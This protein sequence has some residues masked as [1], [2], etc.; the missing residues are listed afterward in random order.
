MW[1][2]LIYLATQS[3]CQLLWRFKHYKAGSGSPLYLMMQKRYETEVTKLSQNNH[4]FLAV[5][6]VGLVLPL[7]YSAIIEKVVTI[8]YKRRWFL[9]RQFCKQHSS[10]IFRRNTCFG[11]H[12]STAFIIGSQPFWTPPTMADTGTISH[13][14][15]SENV[16]SIVMY[17]CTNFGAFV[18]KWTIGLVGRCTIRDIKRRLV[19]LKI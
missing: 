2:V 12:Y 14:S 15:I 1:V 16:H 18:T 10:A 19:S 6:A 13:A 5:L 9:P 11:W 8:V 7:L 4:S 3:C 17:I